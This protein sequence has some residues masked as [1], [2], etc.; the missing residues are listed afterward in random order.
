MASIHNTY[1]SADAP[2][3]INVSHGITK[4]LITDV[5]QSTQYTLPGLENVFAA[6]QEQLEKLLAE[7]VYPRFVKHQITT[8]ATAALADHR[9]RF[10]GLGDCFCLTDPQYD[11]PQSYKLTCTDSNPTA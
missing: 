10:Q 8:S 9:E 7:D 5:K 1:I 3:Q 2:R 4:R 11:V 6:A